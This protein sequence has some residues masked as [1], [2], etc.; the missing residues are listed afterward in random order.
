MFSSFF[1]IKFIQVIYVID[2]NKKSLVPKASIYVDYVCHMSSLALTYGY[3][4]I[5]VMY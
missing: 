2:V 1:K 4:S 3:S 5:N